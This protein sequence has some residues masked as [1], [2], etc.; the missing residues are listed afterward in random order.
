MN[1]RIAN[2]SLSPGAYS[3]AV[4]N[5]A[6]DRSEQALKVML[7]G[8]DPNIEQRILSCSFQVQMHLIALQ[9]ATYFI[10]ADIV[11]KSSGEVME[12]VDSGVLTGFA[13]MFDKTGD[14]SNGM[15]Q[16]THDL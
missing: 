10:C 1:F 4:V 5:A 16:A 13:Y 7:D 11:C 15:A 9:T 8:F 6:I 2:D 14:R 12:Q 3:A